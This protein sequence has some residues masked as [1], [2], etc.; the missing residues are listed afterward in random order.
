MRIKL[1][2]ATAV[3]LLLCTLATMELPE[4]INLVDDTSND[5]SLVVFAENTVVALKVQMLTQV[6]PAR[7]DIQPR[8]ADEY[9]QSHSLIRTFRTSDNDMLHVLCVQRI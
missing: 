6:R 3:G 9:F 5:F 4:L 1:I 7:A 8:Q 2:L